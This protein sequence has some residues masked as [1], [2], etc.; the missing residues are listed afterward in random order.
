MLGHGP[1]GLHRVRHFGKSREGGLGW[2]AFVIVDPNI[3]VYLTMSDS[4]GG[5]AGLAS[6]LVRMPFWSQ[7]TLALL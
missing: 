4:L 3:H 7:G 1:G 5:W 6:D 2:F